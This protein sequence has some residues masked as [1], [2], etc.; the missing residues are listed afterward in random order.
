MIILE[1]MFIWKSCSFYEYHV[2]ALVYVSFV[3]M[4]LSLSTTSIDM[5]ET[6]MAMIRSEDG[7]DPTD[8]LGQRFSL[9]CA[10]KGSTYLLSMLCL[11]YVLMLRVQISFSKTIYRITSCEIVTLIASVLIAVG[12]IIAYDIEIA[13]ELETSHSSHVSLIIL[14][15]LAITCND[16]IINGVLLLIFLLKLCK[17]VDNLD[18][19]Y[20]RPISSNNKQN[21]YNNLT[22]IS[23]Q[24]ENGNQQQGQ[25]QQR[26][27]RESDHDTRYS[28]LS[29]SPT[30]T[31]TATTTA[32]TTAVMSPTNDNYGHYTGYG[33]DNNYGNY[34]NYSNYNNHNNNSHFHYN[35]NSYNNYANYS[36]YSHYHGG[37]N[38]IRPSQ[39]SNNSSNTSHDHRDNASINHPGIGSNGNQKNHHHSPNVHGNYNRSQ[40]GG[41]HGNGNGNHHGQAHKRLKK[42]GKK[43][44]VV[45]SDD[46]QLRIVNL[47]IKV[48]ILTIIATIFAPIFNIFTFIAEYMYVEDFNSDNDND[49]DNNNSSII[50]IIV[51]VGF[52]FRVFQCLGNHIVLYLLFSFNKKEYIFCCKNWHDSMYNCCIKCIK[53]YD[54]HI[55]SQKRR[56]RKKRKKR[57][58]KKLAKLRA[59]QKNN[60]YHVVGNYGR[61]N[62]IDRPSKLAQK[63][64]TNDLRQALLLGV[65][66]Q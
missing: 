30:E 35:N 11:Y 32:T 54:K 66:H 50:M 9:F 37:G 49:N 33:H 23:L 41:G 29:S 28:R 62:H 57:R 18:P 52:L 51:L 56:K 34:S 14:G 59:M 45:Y 26:Q 42:E 60:K 43:V 46:K 58:K 15:A 2:P 4:I 65:S 5:Y 17:T 27:Q 1:I 36:N 16:I 44:S 25:E 19:K 24:S 31:N 21:S 40:G 53:F 13:H 38:I 20:Y 48:S 6:Y 63:N 12:A 10:I 39:F 61:N 47:M 3:A 64:N 55:E 8:I 7:N 22:N